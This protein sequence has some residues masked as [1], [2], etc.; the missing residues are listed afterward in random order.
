MRLVAHYED[1]DVEYV[2]QEQQ[3]RR[4]DIGVPVPNDGYQYVMAQHEIILFG[5]TRHSENK[6]TDRG[7]RPA[8]VNTKWGIETLAKSTG[9]YFPIQDVW[10]RWFYKFF[11]WA[12]W[13]RLPEGKFEGTYVNPKNPNIVYSTYCAGS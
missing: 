5:V 8:V 4:M 10:Q 1:R 6:P 12:S 7:P 9:D 13:Y 11:D 2:T 3:F